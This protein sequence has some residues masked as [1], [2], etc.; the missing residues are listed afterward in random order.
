VQVAKAAGARVVAAVSTA[1]KRE[2]ALRLGADEAFVL[3]EGEL[4]EQIASATGGKGP[5][6]VYDPVGGNLAQPV[7]RSIAWRGRYLVIGFAQGEIPSL[8]LNL[9]LLKGASIV[10]VFWGEYA[11][12][13]PQS[14]GAMLA[15]LCAWYEAGRIKPYIETVLD[16][17]Q[18][19]EAFERMAQRRILGKLVLRNPSP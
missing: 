16:L 4:R 5:D 6:V 7:F 11:R 12:R 17:G 2:V 9:A 8:P 19:P 14:N 18:L 10:G 3:G 13:E 1:A 15:E